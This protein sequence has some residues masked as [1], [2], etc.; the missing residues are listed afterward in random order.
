MRSII[1]KCIKLQ[2]EL[3]GAEGIIKDLRY[4]QL[5]VG[6]HG[7]IWK[8]QQI[9]RGITRRNFSEIGWST[10][11]TQKKLFFFLRSYS[12]DLFIGTHRAKRGGL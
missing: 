8:F 10:F 2:L 6:I 5:S 4:R 9:Y 7:E 3:G 12:G 1:F 11:A